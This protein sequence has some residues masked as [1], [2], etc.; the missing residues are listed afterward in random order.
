[1]GVWPQQSVTC[2]IGYGKH[3]YNPQSV[4]SYMDGCMHITMT[5][6]VRNSDNNNIIMQMFAKDGAILHVANTLPGRF[7]QFQANMQYVERQTQLLYTIYVQ[8]LN[9]PR[10]HN[11]LS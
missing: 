7:E 3:A 2:S 8:Q 10:Q 11:Y 5:S 4:H 6:K 9:S 1:M